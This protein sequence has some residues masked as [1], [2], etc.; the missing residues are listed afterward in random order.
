MRIAAGARR[1]VRLP[2]L[3]PP[4]RG[5]MIRPPT[6]AG[7]WVLVI[8]TASIALWAAMAFG[9]LAHLRRV[10]GGLDA[11]DMRPLGYTA[12][13]A[14]VLLDALGESGREFYARV[15]LRLDAIYPATYALS[16]GLLFW[17][18]TAPGR[19][20]AAPIATA[21]RVVLV[22]LAVAVAAFD[23][24]ENI[25]IGRML[26]A[27]ASIDTGT[28]ETASRMTLLKSL[29]ASVAETCVIVLAV[30]AGLRWR[31]QRPG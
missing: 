27:G 20:R 3:R 14:R 23:Y 13:E 6:V 28:I 22:A 29:T 1:R 18:L 19:L 30:L 26:A 11:F 9:T 7:R 21:V 17:W 10:A 12:G 25:Q 2:H 15:Q 31:S 4:L 16:R 8:L 24:A 5:A